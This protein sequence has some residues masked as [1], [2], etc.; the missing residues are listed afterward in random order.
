MYHEKEKEKEKSKEEAG[1]GPYF[2][3]ALTIEDY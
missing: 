2:K 1:K 3:K